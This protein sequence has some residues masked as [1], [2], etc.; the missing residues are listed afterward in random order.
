[1]TMRLNANRRGG[2]RGAEII[3]DGVSYKKGRMV[4]RTGL[5]GGV[6]KGTAG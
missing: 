1:M 3:L 4:L 6:G 5:G 2:D